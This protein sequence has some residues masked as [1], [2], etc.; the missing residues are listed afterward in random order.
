MF[1]FCYFV[2]FW[3]VFVTRFVTRIK[4]ICY[5]CRG[6]KNIVAMARQKESVK[7]KNFVR[8]RNKKLA[9]GNKSLYLGAD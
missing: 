5:L 9:N 8:L 2:L 7:P 1:I 4:R 6:N 3:C